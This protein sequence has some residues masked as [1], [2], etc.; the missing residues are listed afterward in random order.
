ME[1]M[2]L[3]DKIELVNFHTFEKDKLLVIRKIVGNF[4][5][6]LQERHPDFEK[7][8]LAFNAVHETKFEI[9]GGLKIGGKDYHSEIVDFN[10][11][12]AINSVLGKLEGEI[13]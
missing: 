10:L 5:K 6:N 12:F 7:L 3:G 11:F 4:V 1:A 13:R 2:Q 9:K 8:S